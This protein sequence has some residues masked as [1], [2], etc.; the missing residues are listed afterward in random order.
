MTLPSMDAAQIPLQPLLSFI[1]AANRCAYSTMY[2]LRI[3]DTSNPA[4][5]FKKTIAALQNVSA[6]CDANLSQRLSISYH[7]SVTANQRGT[8]HKASGEVAQY[9]FFV[10]FLYSIAR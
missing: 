3:L 7:Q 10:I 1:S 4:H 2:N 5:F 9:L 6:S 8:R